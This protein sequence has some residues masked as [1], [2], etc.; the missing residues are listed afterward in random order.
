MREQFDFTGPA[1]E[2]QTQ[3]LEGPFARLVARPQG[4]QQTGDQSQVDLDRH[5]VLT[6]RQ[7]MLAAQNTFEPTEEKFHRPPELVRQGDQFGWQ[8]EPIGEEMEGRRF[9]SVQ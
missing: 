2:I 5:T 1:R 6:G 4:Y 7:Q 8:I 3:H 9:V